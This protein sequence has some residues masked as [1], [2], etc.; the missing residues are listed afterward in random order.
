MIDHACEV[1]REQGFALPGQRI[2]VTAGVPAGHARCDQSA[3]HRL[4]E[5]RLRAPD[6]R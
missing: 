1:A 6:R 5:L 4:V 2:I 3:P